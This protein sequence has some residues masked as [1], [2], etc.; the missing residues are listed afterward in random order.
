MVKQKILPNWYQILRKWRTAFLI[1]PRCFSFSWW[2]SVSFAERRSVPTKHISSSYVRYTT[3]LCAMQPLLPKASCP[4]PEPL[5]F[6]GFVKIVPVEK[7]RQRDARPFTKGLDRRN[8]W[9]LRSAL[10]QVINRRRRFSA[11]YRGA[12]N[13]NFLVF[14]NFFNPLNNRV[15]QPHTH[16]VELRIV[17]PR[18]QCKKFAYFYLVELHDYWQ[19]FN[20]WIGELYFQCNT[21]RTKKKFIWICCIINLQQKT[22]REDPYEL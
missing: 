9:A 21:L 7:F 5:L 22:Q 20:L 19:Y 6:F 17:I 1:L 4:N 13:F 11:A 14:T 16:L 3:A 10:H 12:A 2:T 8:F 15:I 18:F